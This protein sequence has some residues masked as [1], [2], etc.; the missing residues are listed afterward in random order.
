MLTK[1]NNEPFSDKAVGLRRRQMPFEL[2][3]V[4]NDGAF[5]KGGMWGQML[6]MIP[7]RNRVV[8][9]HAYDRKSNADLASF[10]AEWTG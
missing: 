5:G 9:W 1:E 10:A 3:L 6:L 2:Q 8:M 4:H 7:S